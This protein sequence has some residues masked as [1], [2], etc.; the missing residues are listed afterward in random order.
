[1]N[2][3]QEKMSISRSYEQLRARLAARR[4]AKATSAETSR[5]SSV[6]NSEADIPEEPRRSEEPAGPMQAT[7]FSHQVIAVK[8]THKKTSI[9]RYYI[10]VDI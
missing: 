1:M 9:V 7:Y 6:A 8:L 2:T 3:F 5:C 10:R 4:Q